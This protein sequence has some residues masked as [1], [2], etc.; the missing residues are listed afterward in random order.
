MWKY[1]N[2]TPDPN[3]LTDTLS[4]PMANQHIVHVL[5]IGEHLENCT[6]AV[7]ERLL[8]FATVV[9]ER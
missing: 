8:P 3:R 1:L 6:Y 2:D 5:K 9:A 4:F 7:V